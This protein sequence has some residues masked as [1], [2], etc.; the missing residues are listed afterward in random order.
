MQTVAPRSS[1]A[2]FHAHPAP[3]GTLASATSCTSPGDSG[4]PATARARTRAAFT[5]T[6]PKSCSKANANTA[7]AV[8]GP[9]PGSA[10][11][12]AS[13]AGTT[14]PAFRRDRSLF[15]V[16][17]YHPGGAGYALWAGAVTAAMAEDG[18]PAPG[19]TLPGNEMRCQP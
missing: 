19:S 4:R 9:T 3:A 5:S 2:W 7:R 13:V 10:T 14:G 8:Y 17:G 6:T 12:S 16:D 1:T 15:S 18:L 11:S